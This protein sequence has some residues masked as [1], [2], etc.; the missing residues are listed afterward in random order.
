MTGW[1]AARAVGDTGERVANDVVATFAA[2]SS[3][4][5]QLP[6][7]GTYR[8]F[9]IGSVEAVQAASQA[10]VEVRH[11]ASGAAG[12]VIRADP[13][14][15]QGRENRPGLDLLFSFTVAA[16]G[17]H[18]LRMALA[19][20]AGPVTLRVTRYSAITAGAAMRSFGLATLFSVLL[21]VNAVVWFRR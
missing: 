12:T 15:A 9:A 17:P 13:R 7:A 19:P 2:E 18:A 16:A 5:L 10:T 1:A 14:R 8:V 11:H 20:T 21:V 3:R 6:S 4:V